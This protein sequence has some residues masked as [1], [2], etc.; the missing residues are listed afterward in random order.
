[1]LLK[2]GTPE[3]NLQH[4]RKELGVASTCPALAIG[5]GIGLPGLAGSQPRSRLHEPFSGK[6]DSEKAEHL[7]PC[8]CFC[9][10]HTPHIPARPAHT[11]LPQTRHTPHIPAR[12]AHTLLPQ[13]RHT[14]HIPA[15]PTHPRTAHTSQHGL[16]TLLPQ[17][18]THF[19]FQDNTG[20]RCSLREEVPGL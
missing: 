12:P 7:R 13:T 4:Q 8:C 17:I 5:D 19:S 10:R 18:N 14:P 6:L 1:M 15:R 2:H 9:T 20:M 16:H 11:P 3:L